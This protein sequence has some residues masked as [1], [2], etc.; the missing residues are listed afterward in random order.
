[1]ALRLLQI[2]DVHLFL[3]HLEKEKNCM[4]R[5]LRFDS[6]AIIVSNRIF[7]A[8]VVVVVVVVV[9]AVDG[10]NVQTR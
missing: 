2:I 3:G 8:V 5:L 7:L 1:M 9:V 6:V 4:V 10:V